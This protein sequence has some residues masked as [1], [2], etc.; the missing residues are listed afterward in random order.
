MFQIVD[1]EF[2][3]L[4][5]GHRAEVASDFEISFMR[6]IDG[7]FQFCPRDIHVRLER[8]DA[9]VGPVV[10]ELA[11][12]VGAAQLVHLKE[13]A[14]SAFKVGPGDVDMRA[15]KM[16]GV[17]FALEVQVGVGFDAARGAH[18]G[19]AAGKIE[20]RGGESHLR[21]K[22]GLVGVPATIEIGPGNIK[23]MVV[24]ADDPGHDSVAV[25]VEHD[26]VLC[27][28]DV[29]G[30]LDGGDLAAFEGDVLVFERRVSGAIDYA[31][32]G[33]HDLCGLHANILLHFF[34]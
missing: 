4:F 33:Q 3:R 5:V 10:H 29:G 22:H 31:D 13:I 8:R 19:D 9:V 27:I 11:C 24:H 2:S 12:F 23:E 20:T 21:H 1:A 14:A 32:V 34:R 17:N 15:G 18:G 6:G 26:G 30:G 7:G 16:S 28:R 25:K